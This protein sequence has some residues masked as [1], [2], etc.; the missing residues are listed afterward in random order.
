MRLHLVCAAIIV[1]TAAGAQAPSAKQLI[2]AWR[3]AN[4][5]CRGST[6]PESLKTK[7]ECDRRERLGG[8]LDQI[9][10]CYGKKG[11]AGYQNAW[12]RCEPN[13]ER[14]NDLKPGQ[15]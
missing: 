10:W 3:T 8:R 5:E 7:S 9:G 6:D 1:S 13:S 2:A 4:G 12:H 14:Q 15:F 11:E